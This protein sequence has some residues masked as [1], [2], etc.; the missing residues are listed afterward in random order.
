M[1]INRGIEHLLAQV[2]PVP[3]IQ[4]STH[5]SLVQHCCRFQ[6]TD[7]LVH[8]PQTLRDVIDTTLDLHRFVYM[9]DRVENILLPK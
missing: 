7:M 8:S 6:A 2:N 4:L 5:F 1:G 9:H 3:T